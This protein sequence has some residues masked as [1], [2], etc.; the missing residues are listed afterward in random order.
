MG[1]ELPQLLQPMQAIN[2]P[3]AGGRFL[4][5]LR[6]E[7]TGLLEHARAVFT[8]GSP[9]SVGDAWTIPPVERLKKA[10]IENHSQLQELFFEGLRASQRLRHSGMIQ[11]AN[12]VKW[13]AGVVRNDPAR[14]VW[15]IDRLDGVSASS[16]WVYVAESRGLRH[17]FNTARELDM[18]RMMT[19]LPSQETFNT[20]R[21]THLEALARKLFFET[22]GGRARPDTEGLE[23]A[24][25]QRGVGTH[26]W[27]IGN[28]DDM[29]FYRGPRETEFRVLVDYKCPSEPKDE[30]EEIQDDYAVQL[31]NYAL[32]AG[33]AGR[34]VAAIALA[35][36]YVADDIAQIWA[37]MLDADPR[38]IESV[39]QQARFA[40]DKGLEEQVKLTVQKVTVNIE[41]Q[42]EILV[43]CKAADD[44]IQKGELSP[45]PARKALEIDTS[46]LEQARAIDRSLSR[47][48]VLNKELQAREAL[49]KGQLREVLGEV[50]TKTTQT[51]LS[52]CSAA[53]TRKT[54]Y[55][56]AVNALRAMGVATDDLA[57][58]E[59]QP[60]LVFDKPA[61]EKAIV[62]A[63]MPID[64]FIERNLQ[65]GLTRAKSGPSADII[66]RLKET[67]RVDVDRLIGDVSA[68]GEAPTD[69]IGEALRA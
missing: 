27:L 20:Y 8:A 14:L 52:A 69:E 55:E 36:L 11:A 35:H 7:E 31:H 26:S 24:R 15:H 39:Y 10:G 67:S 41:L 61:I 42:K 48:L 44:R 29:A 33:A 16:A 51:G 53:T 50:D 13:M 49:Y 12:A 23:A 5:G 30:D 45:W 54:N 2:A 6:M 9:A 46:E 62:D 63:G 37:R 28:P 38:N 19:R 21:G 32:L 17:R 65:I 64:R 60:V 56:S 3:R 34:G 47:V 4:P 68:I 1:Q 25:R 66:S 59:N 58:V 22:R 18:V 57:K 40:Y 43:V